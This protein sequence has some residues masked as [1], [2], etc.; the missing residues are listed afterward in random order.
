MVESD[1]CPAEDAVQAFL[2]YLVEPMLP[3]K[4]FL[5][6]TPSESLQQSVAKQVLHLC[7]TLSF[8][9]FD[10]SVQTAFVLRYSMLMHRNVIMLREAPNFFHCFLSEE[11]FLCTVASSSENE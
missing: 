8:P 11:S 4:S 2:E 6:G 5:Q 9:W 7:Y 3:A 10:W 1:I